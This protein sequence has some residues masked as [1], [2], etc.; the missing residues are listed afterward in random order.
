MKKTKISLSFLALVFAIA[1]TA[2]GQDRMVI[3]LADNSR[4]TTMLSLIQRITFDGD[5]MLLK[6]TT[7][8]EKHYSF[9]DIESITFLEPV[10]CNP[11][12]DLVSEKIGTNAI[13]LNWSKPE[14]SSQVEGFS[15]FRNDQLQ[16]E[17]LLMET[18]YL[19]D[20]L[21]DGE[22]EYYLL[23]YYENS[24]VSDTSNHAIEVILEPV[25][26][27]PVNDLVSEKIGTNAI[28]LNWSKP[29]G[30]S[31]VEGFSIFRN[32][33]LQNEELFVETSY[34]DDDLLAGVYEYYVIVHCSSDNISDISNRV[35][36]TITVG[37]REMSQS[38]D[39]VLYPNPTTG[40]LRVMSEELRIERVEIFDVYGRKLS[41]NHLIISSSHQK[42]DISHLTS[43]IY[44]I[45]IETDNG[46][47]TK[48]IIKN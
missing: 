24:C 22:Y 14:G 17:E 39:I 26:C 6:T 1:T 13:R 11:V 40:E 5:D 27:D 35:T 41:S 29:E 7:S 30:N 31:Q 45:K 20:N 48:K 15:I 44:F 43:G 28:R 38:E 25:F 12:N 34:I 21:P 32:D 19:D 23:T 33:Q 37:I 16:N 36:E 10:F 4:D 3:N 46:S 42:I 8:T 18:F 9:E 47:V 2:F